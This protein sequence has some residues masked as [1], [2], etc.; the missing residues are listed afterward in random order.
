MLAHVLAHLQALMSFR[1]SPTAASAH[2]QAMAKLSQVC[3]PSCPQGRPWRVLTFPEQNA[4]VKQDDKACISW[5]KQILRAAEAELGQYT[6][7]IGRDDQE[8]VGPEESAGNGGSKLF[9][10]DFRCFARLS[11]SQQHVC[12]VPKSSHLVVPLPQTSGP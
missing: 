11:C 4:L 7:P 9:P 12:R 2:V 8:R 10:Q 1:L 5:T 3:A 6:S